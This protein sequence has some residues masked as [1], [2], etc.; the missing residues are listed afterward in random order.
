MNEK[1]QGKDTDE[2]LIGVLTAISIVS[3][4]LAKN[5]AALVSDNPLKGTRQNVQEKQYCQKRS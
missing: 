4:R 2:D 1:V 3:K 5:I